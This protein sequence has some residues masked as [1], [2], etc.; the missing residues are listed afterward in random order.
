[1]R[2]VLGLMAGLLLSVASRSASAQFLT[3]QWGPTDLGISAVALTASPSFS[4]RVAGFQFATI[5]IV[6]TR[7]AA[8]AINV[9]CTAGPSASLSG[10]VAVASVNG[11]TGA[12][13]LVDGSFSY[14]VSASGNKRFIISPLN[15]YNL[16]CTFTGTAATS[17]DLISVYL[18]LGGTK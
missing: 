12:I 16:T 14:A 6:Y 3:D 8:T 9:A 5:N 18:R 13:T 4:W 15:D 17:G 1:M 11:T 2:R 7:A 10:P